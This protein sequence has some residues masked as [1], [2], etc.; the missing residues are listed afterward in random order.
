ASQCVGCGRCEK[1]CP[2][3]IEIRKNLKE[4]AKSLEGP[5]YKMGRKVAKLFVKM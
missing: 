4:A 1:R 5:L 3:K 2:Q